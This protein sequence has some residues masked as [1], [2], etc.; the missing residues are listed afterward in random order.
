MAARAIKRIG[1]AYVACALPIFADPQFNSGGLQIAIGSGQP[2]GPQAP[3]FK[4]AVAACGGHG[5][6]RAVSL[7]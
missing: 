5:T 2:A 4:H 1:H 7:P 6:Q 3:A